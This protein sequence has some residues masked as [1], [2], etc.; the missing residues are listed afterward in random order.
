MKPI[1][2][3]LLML[4]LFVA[5]G[6]Q[7]PPAPAVPPTPSMG[8]ADLPPPKRRRRLQPRL[9]RPAAAPAAA[10]AAPAAGGG[11]LAKGEADLQ[12]TC[13]ACHAGG[14]LAGRANWV[15]RRRGPRASPKAWTRCTCTLSRAFRARPA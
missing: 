8:D 15:T 13:F 2:L 10:P 3:S 9:R 6:K 12:Q 1:L 14:W 5:C 7:E 11:N 4:P